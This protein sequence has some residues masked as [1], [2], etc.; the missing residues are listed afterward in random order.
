ME[1]LTGH[2]SFVM[3]DGVL[4]KSII[5]SVSTV[6]QDG[7]LPVRDRSTPPRAANL[8]QLVVGQ[9]ERPF[10]VMGKDIPLPCPASQHWPVCVFTTCNLLSSP[11]RFFISMPRANT[12]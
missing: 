12:R 10:R 9:H 8:N 7:S 11:A 5:H 3:F 4:E 1:Q 2:L 6:I